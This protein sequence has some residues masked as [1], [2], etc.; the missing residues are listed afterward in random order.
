MGPAVPERDGEGPSAGRAQG[1]TPLPAWKVTGVV[2][3]PQPPG[4]LGHL[5]PGD[6]DTADPGCSGQQIHTLV[7]VG[8]Q[9]RNILQFNLQGTGAHLGSGWRSGAG[10]KGGARHLK[11]GAGYASTQ[12]WKPATRKEQGRTKE[13]DGPSPRRPGA[14][15]PGQSPR[16][17]PQGHESARRTRAQGS[18][19]GGLSVRRG[20]RGHSALRGQS[21]EGA[22]QPGSAE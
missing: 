12:L 5:Q 4:A 18:G 20:Q 22:A 11:V 16:P 19:T 2:R 15:S 13:R 8:L 7:W 6:V 10:A 21:R 14:C 1:P 3:G 17:Q 9:V